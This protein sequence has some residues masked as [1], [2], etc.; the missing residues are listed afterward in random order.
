MAPPAISSTPTSPLGQ[1]LEGQFEVTGLGSSSREA[2]PLGSGVYS[3]SPTLHH[4]PDLENPIRSSSQRSIRTL[5][6]VRDAIVVDFFGRHLF[7]GG[8][9]ARIIQQLGSFPGFLHPETP[10]HQWNPDQKPDF[11]LIGDARV[12][13]EAMAPMMK[14]NQATLEA[15]ILRAERGMAY[16]NLTLETPQGPIPF[17]L[18][19]LGSRQWEQGS[20]PYYNLRASLL[21]ID[22]PVSSYRYFQ[23]SKSGDGY[24]ALPV[25]TDLPIEEKDRLL[26]I[27][28]DFLRRSIETLAWRNHF[29]AEDL[30]QRRYRNQF[31]NYELY[32]IFDY[33][34]GP[35]QA[36]RYRDQVAS[37]LVPPLQSYL[38]QHPDRLQVRHPELGILSPERITPEN[39]PQLTF[40]WQLGLGARVRRYFSVQSEFLRIN[41]R[42]ARQTARNIASNATVDSKQEVTWWEYGFRK[43]GRFFGI[44]NKLHP[45]VYE[46]SAS[47]FPQNPVDPTVESRARLG[48]AGNP[49]EKFLIVG[50]YDAGNESD[51]Q[52][53]REILEYARA[54][55]QRGS[56]PNVL[57]KGV[58]PS[59]FNLSVRGIPAVYYQLVNA[60]YSEGAHE[61][62]LVG[63]EDTRQVFEAFL[64]INAE[65]I[66]KRGKRFYFEPQAGSF[67]QNLRAGYK[68]FQ[69]AEGPVMVGCAD[70]P[71]IDVERMAFHPLRFLSQWVVSPNDK[72]S[73]FHSMFKN[74]HLAGEREGVFHP[75]KEGNLLI[76]PGKVDQVPWDLLQALFDSRKSMATSPGSRSKLGILKE[77]MFGADWRDPRRYPPHLYESLYFAGETLALSASQEGNLGRVGDALAKKSQRAKSSMARQ[78]WLQ[79]ARLFWNLNYLNPA[80]VG[81]KVAPMTGNVDSAERLLRHRVGFPQP[82]PSSVMPGD[83]TDTGGVLDIDGVLDLILAKLALEET[84]N[85]EKVFPHWE[86]IA[87]HGELLHGRGLTIPNPQQVAQRVNALHRRLHGDF[88]NLGF[89]ES[90]LVRGGFVSGVDPLLPEGGVN[91]DYMRLLMGE[92]QAGFIPLA[93]EAYSNRGEYA[94]SVAE[95]PAKFFS[96]SSPVVDLSPEQRSA[97]RFAF[98]QINVDPE[99]FRSL[100]LEQNMDRVH[101]AL[102]SVG[103]KEWGAE[104][105]AQVELQKYLQT[106]LEGTTALS[107]VFTGMKAVEI[108]RRYDSLLA[109]AE[110]QK[111]YPWLVESLI[112]AQETLATLPEVRSLQS[113]SRY[114]AVAEQSADRAYVRRVGETPPAYRR[115]G[116]GAW[117]PNSSSYEA[118]EQR[119]R[120]SVV[121]GPVMLPSDYHRLA[122]Q[123]DLLPS[124]VPHVVAAAAGVQNGGE[125]QRISAS[126]MTPE[127]VLQWAQTSDG[128]K[129]FHEHG[130]SLRNNFANRLREGGPGLAVG[131]GSVFVLA[132]LSDALGLDRRWNSH[133]RF[134][135]E[136]GAGHLLSAGTHSVNEV[137]LQRA[138]GS[139][140][141]HSSFRR[142]SGGSEAA[143]QLT[144]RGSSGLSQDLSASLM[145]NFQG[146]G[147]VVG[148]AW[149]G[150]KGLFALPFRSAWNM[151]PGLMSA[152]L[153]DKL[154]SEKILGL[155][156][157][158]SLRQGIHLGAFFL[159]DA[160]R[161]AV[162]SSR[163]S[164]FR[165]RSMQWASR[166][167][168]VGFMADMAFTGAMRLQKGSFNAVADYQVHQLADHYHDQRLS[169]FSGMLNGTLELMAPNL[170]SWWDSMEWR[171]G[172]FQPNAHLRRARAE[173]AAQSQGLE[174]QVLSQLQ[175]I[176]LNGFGD[177]KYQVSFYQSVDFRFLRDELVLPPTRRN[178][179]KILRNSLSHDGV[180]QGFFSCPDQAAR[181]KWVQNRLGAYSLSETEANSLLLHLTM[182]TVRSQG[183][184]LHQV[185]SSR[186]G[187]LG[188]FFDERGRVNPG[189]ETLLLTKVLGEGIDSRMLLKIRRRGLYQRLSQLRSGA[190]EQIP[191]EMARLEAVARQLA[192]TA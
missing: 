95:D 167:F 77:I 192:Q 54:E 30:V 16:F 166:A 170:M 141:S 73:M 155:D 69:N 46:S 152:A 184:A 119:G 62:V 116:R 93:F 82:F 108:L 11:N 32:R 56:I 176:F 113:L 190:P 15:N 104:A 43:F 71:L 92:R 135:F 34:K 158:S 57:F 40:T 18:G 81:K 41:G 186:S 20:H 162:P 168:S 80:P 136:V 187:G 36:A 157:E 102:L 86:R 112:L 29:T 106:S 85:P 87:G 129:F 189:C 68:R 49:V 7:C 177:D 160:Y 91:P 114:F 125:L 22:G 138:M 150:T 52:V 39:F 6:D 130:D 142:V 109:P 64:E 28:Q 66:K 146:S 139:P 180:A 124:R 128:Q 26:G 74:Y 25:V 23:I 21:P 171:G 48:R 137:F 47:F 38:L 3:A 8:K 159:P 103:A 127:R 169:G 96:I 31:V 79:G 145:R 121:N 172:S 122:L 10:F 120:S 98:Q 1:P 182:E 132:P 164:F 42:M 188:K 44:E 149:S 53:Y 185:V 45:R 19:I 12:I 2:P 35:K 76:F 117:L 140:F 179:L 100:L 84:K 178:A 55:L 88:V 14:W 67:T 89:S 4:R 133:E 101:D 37:I 151:G 143:L 134:V 33:T 58:D 72:I 9:G 147:G 13:L 51:P 111:V 154:L 174:S 24:R 75:S 156:A 115:S 131:L 181:V 107:R 70:T 148:R 163:P 61:T 65:E 97:E 94:R 90:Q 153:T 5:G 126:R 105:Q 17:K 191:Q 144:F 59:K 123:L 27:Q 83:H 183:A 99:H 173:V 175:S 60:L 110:F 50:G 118:V 78:F 161:I 63:C 165:S